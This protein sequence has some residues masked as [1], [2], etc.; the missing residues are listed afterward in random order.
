MNFYES[1]LPFEL[2]SA[3]TLHANT[4]GFAVIKGSVLNIGISSGVNFKLLTGSP[5]SN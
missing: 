5:L 4:N 3:S 2:D 1:S